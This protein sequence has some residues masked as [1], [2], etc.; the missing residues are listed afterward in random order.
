MVLFLFCY[1]FEE[2]D[3]ILMVIVVFL[4]SDFLGL[5]EGYER[6]GSMYLGWGW[7]IRILGDVCF[8]DDLIFLVLIL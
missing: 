2:C 5:W 7:Y 8:L 4:D 6:D 3:I 1:F